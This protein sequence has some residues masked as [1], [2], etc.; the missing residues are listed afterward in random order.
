M[1]LIL[2]RKFERVSGDSGEGLNVY[3][4]KSF[5]RHSAV[6]QESARAESFS[7]ERY[8]STT[9]KKALAR[10]KPNWLRGLALGTVL[11]IDRLPTNVE[12]IS[13]AIDTRQKGRVVWQ[14]SV[15]A[16][17][18]Q[19][20]VLGLHTWMQVYLTPVYGDLLFQ[21]AEEGFTIERFKKEKDRLMALLIKLSE[22]GIQEIQMPRKNGSV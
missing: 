7:S 1:H 8:V 2:P 3:Q 10:C 12:L 21:F 19:R 13:D 9:R 15:I 22:V 20:L 17:R 5:N 11:E 18:D 4:A 16:V 14:W 6:I